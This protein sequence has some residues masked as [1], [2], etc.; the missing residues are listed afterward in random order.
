M[1]RFLGLAVLALVAALA[2]PVFVADHASAQQTELTQRADIVDVQERLKNL[3]WYHGAIDGIVG[4]GT[5]SAA[6]AYRQAAGLPR[7]SRIDKDLQ[8]HLHFINPDLRAG[9]SRTVQVDPDVRK[10]QELLKLLGYYPGAVDGISGPQTRSAVERF[11]RDQ[12]LS[13]GS[14]VDAQLLQQLDAEL[15]R[16]GRI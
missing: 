2:A 8:L 15:A 4:S 6:S 16:R 11:R 9:S 13:A 3:G 5:R 10:A 7:S 1:L 14:R 12:R